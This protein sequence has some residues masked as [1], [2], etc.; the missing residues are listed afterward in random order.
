MEI[1]LCKVNVHFP[2]RFARSIHVWGY[3]WCKSSAREMLINFAHLYFRN[4]IVTGPI[5]VYTE[6]EAIRALLLEDVAILNP[7]EYR[8]L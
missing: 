4:E 6:F 8:T 7:V 5:Y 3:Y 1:P 2:G